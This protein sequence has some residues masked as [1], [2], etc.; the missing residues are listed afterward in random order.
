MSTVRL[1]RSIASRQA[2]AVNTV[3]WSGFDVSARKHSRQPPPAGASPTYNT[4]LGKSS[5]N[6]RGLISFS[7]RAEMIPKTISRNVWLAVGTASIMM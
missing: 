4:R 5:K 7:A 2:S 1:S 3:G 6:T